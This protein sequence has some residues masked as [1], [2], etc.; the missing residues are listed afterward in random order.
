MRGS[1]TKKGE[2]TW[3]IVDSEQQSIPQI[4]PLSDEDIPDHLRGG[5]ENVYDNNS[6]VMRHDFIDTSEIIFSHQN[7]MELDVLEVRLFHDVQ[8]TIFNKVLDSYSEDGDLYYWYGESG[9]NYFN[10]QIHNE[11]CVG[12][13]II[14]D[15]YYDFMTLID[16]VV[17]VQQLDVA[18]MP[19]ATDEIEGGDRTLL[20]L[21]SHIENHNHQKEVLMRDI[22]TKASSSE[23]NEQS[24]TDKTE[25]DILCLYTRSA[26]EALCNELRGKNCDKKYNDY[27][28]KMNDKCDHSVSLTVSAIFGILLYDQRTIELFF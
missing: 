23:R 5:D 1:K 2:S 13:L 10:I 11:S 24:S 17:M 7:G 21:D 22:A 25:I 12:T 16:R 27:V 28:G 4:L 15:Q 20:R 6:Y 9:E 26:L 3:S 18:S 8:S 19:S 14:G